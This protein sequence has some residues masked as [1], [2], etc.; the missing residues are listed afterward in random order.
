MRNREADLESHSGQE[1][2]LGELDRPKTPAVRKRLAKSLA[3]FVSNWRSHAKFV[4]N[5]LAA[6]ATVGAM[7]GGLA[8]Y[9][10]TYR[11]VTEQLAGQG[12]KALAADPALPARQREAPRLSIA[13]LPFENLSQDRSQD[14]FGEGIVEN[15]TTD[16][17]MNI[18]NLIV[19]ASGPSFIYQDPTIDPRRLGR[20]F[21]VRYLL[22]GSVLRSGN[23]VRINARLIDASDGKQLWAERFDG[24]VSNVLDLQDQV[25]S[26]I[27]SSLRFALPTVCTRRAQRH[28]NEDAFDIML[29]GQAALNDERRQGINPH[30]RAE[31]YYRKATELESDN[32]DTL[33]GL[34]LVLAEN[35]FNSR[36]LPRAQQPSPEQVQA[37][38]SEVNEL[39]KKATHKTPAS[40][41][42]HL[43]RAFLYI[44]DHKFDDARHQLEQA[45]TINPN[46]YFSLRLLSVDYEYLGMP[47]KALPIFSEIYR[48]TA[49]KV[50]AYYLTLF[51][52][53]QSLL[54]L[55][56][57]KDAI[58]KL[59][60][61]QAFRASPTVDG[62]LAIAYAQE[63]NFALAQT[64]FQA[65]REWYAANSGAPTIKAMRASF[66]ESSDDPN[67]L[68]IV[69]ATVL[70]GYRKLG[71]PEE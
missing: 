5:R 25:T 15:L 31:S 48:R 50:P 56:Q 16:L 1:R 12:G 44:Y 40:S 26:R 11:V 36:I 64:H 2:S 29:R 32:A 60:E 20:E 3:Q 52:W 18:P 59:Q 10:V 34:G 41:D 7:L 43:A 4:R 38:K 37:T 35:L 46:D 13:V 54:L 6:I 45:L 19:V 17:S 47:E 21:N 66:R 28:D 49:G 57:W 55:A 69:N 70:D 51:D 62:Y 24:D 23:Q 58:A 9:L 61:A 71:V 22:L 30:K 63:A 53:G 68:E 14:Y 27:S 42:A 8:G 65:W 67:Y 39:L 33:T